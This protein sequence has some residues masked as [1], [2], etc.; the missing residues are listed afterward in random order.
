MATRAPDYATITFSIPIRTVS[1]ANMRTHW[2]AKAKRVKA[3]RQ[4]V[5]L[6]SRAAGCW[7]CT[8]GCDMWSFALDVSF[9]DAK[10][11]R[12]LLTR[13]A[14]RELDTDN[15]AISS[16][17]PRDQ[18]AHHL[19]IDDR[20]KSVVWQYE[21]RKGKAREY[22]LEVQIGYLSGSRRGRSPSLAN[23]GTP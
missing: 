8:C 13:V 3:Q 12:V 1:E 18:I 16:K 20:S 17:G 15:L 9:N 5:T 19:G 22:A 11:L 23:G 6:A 10:P 7:V 14:P 4:A 2:S 21:Q